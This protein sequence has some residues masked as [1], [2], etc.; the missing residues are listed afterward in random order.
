M[1]CSNWFRF[2][3]SDYPGNW[4]FRVQIRSWVIYI[5]TP[6]VTTFRINPRDLMF[7]LKFQKPME[8]FIDKLWDSN[9]PF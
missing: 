8:F 1:N 7:T 5:H 9:I 3:I 4:S 6:I 2:Y